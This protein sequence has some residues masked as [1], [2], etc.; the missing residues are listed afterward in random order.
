LSEK[1][2][3]SLPVF[4][5]EAKPRDKGLTIISDFLIAPLERRVLD[6]TADYFDYAKIGQSLPLIADRSVLLERIRYYHDYG[7]RVMSGGTL[8]QV[9]LRKG[10]ISETLERLRSLGF[11]DVEISELK[12]DIAL[13]KK[14]EIIEIIESLS[15]D[16][17]FEVG[18]KFQNTNVASLV[19]KIEEAI[20]LK[21]QK[22]VIDAGELGEGFG[23]FDQ[24]GRIQWE[25]LNE[26]VGRFGPPKLIFEAP[27]NQQR[28]GLILEFGP[29]VNLASVHLE[30]LPLLEMHRQGLTSET[31]GITPSVR[32]V[33]GSPSVKFVY[34]L[35]KSEHPIDQGALLQKSGLPKRTLQASLSYLVEKGLIREIADMQDL[36]K[37]KYT[38]R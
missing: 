32:N 36:R 13:E 33:E 20:N 35:I 24:D 27:K 7:I 34:H 30:D 8:V 4:A 12:S 23:I 17:V 28:V 15:M 3:S 26:I 9:A 37:H 16:Y 22:V 25:I 38:P 29:S 21:S 11:D 5:R 18:E 10:L 31:L 19:T 14:Q 2:K 1:L 6:L